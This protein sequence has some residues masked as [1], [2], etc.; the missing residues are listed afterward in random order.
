[1]ISLR[2]TQPNS[3][4]FFMQDQPNY[5]MDEWAEEPLRCLSKTEFEKL[6]AHIRKN[7]EVAKTLAASSRTE[8]QTQP[9]AGPDP[10][11]NPVGEHQSAPGQSTQAVAPH[12]EGS[13]EDKTK[14]V[15]RPHSSARAGLR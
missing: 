11:A 8:E 9:L 3:E 10:P 13:W 14:H 2:W 12:G 4:T 6:R 1:M 7:N 15:P 5:N